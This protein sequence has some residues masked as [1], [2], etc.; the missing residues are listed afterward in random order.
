MM[1]HYCAVV[2][3]PKL[4]LRGMGK[5]KMTMDLFLD[6][7]IDVIHEMSYPFFHRRV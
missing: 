3:Q 7:D 5:N 1:I 4:V 2:N 6:S